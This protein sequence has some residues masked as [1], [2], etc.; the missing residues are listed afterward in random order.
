M[1]E[2]TFAIMLL[3]IGGTGKSSVADELKRILQT[4]G[5]TVCL[6]R[7]DELRKALAPPGA[8][9]FSKDPLVMKAIYEKAIRIFNERLKQGTSL[10]IDAG[11]S[12]ES[13]RQEI[14]LRVPGIRIVHVSCPL[15]LAILRDTRR[16]LRLHYRHE[17]GRFLH[18]R[19]L[20]DLVNPFKNSQTRFPQPGITYPFEYPAC[21]SLHISSF[22]SD[23]HSIAVRI[24]AEFGLINEV[25]LSR[26]K[27]DVPSGV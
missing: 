7:F 19:A 25:M 21:A 4:A 9:P 5:E 8:D 24:L 2:R 1:T 13:L 11:L 26:D 17:R 6:I 27:S 15:W 23:S 12:V 14:K 3:G 20:L 16:S 22:R 18:L 10:I